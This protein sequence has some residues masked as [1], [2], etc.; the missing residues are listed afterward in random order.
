MLKGFP[1]APMTCQSAA[2]NPT[3]SIQTW[4]PENGKNSSNLHSASFTLCLNLDRLWLR[5]TWTQDDSITC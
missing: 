4:V 5:I 3:N 2:H 1:S